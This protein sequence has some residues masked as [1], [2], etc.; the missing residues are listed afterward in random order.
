M[1]QPL[2]KVIVVGNPNKA[3]VPEV[4]EAAVAALK[5]AVEVVSIDLNGDAM[6]DGI[7]ADLAFVFGGDGA[8]LHAARRLGD[9]PMP[10][11]GVKLGKLGFLATLTDENLEADLR[12]VAAGEYT[13]TSAMKLNCAVE[14]N[15]EIVHRSSAVNDAVVSRGAL[16]RLIPIDLLIDGEK[17]TTYNADGIIV[18]TPLGSTAHS[19]AA[20]GPILE[21]GFDAM[22]L[23]P[24][25]PHTLSN[26]PLAI[27]AERQIRLCIVERP[28]GTALTV[29]G[30]IFQDLQ[31]GDC[32]TVARS[33]ARFNLVR[34]TGHSYFRTLRE[35]LG[36]SGHVGT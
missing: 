24:I 8:I 34:A 5:P 17:V 26:R 14:R 6:L 4:I 21:P 23:T 16:S 36:W 32:V 15:G 35:K 13:V 20:G 11:C 22:V 33:E 1:G 12:A 19:L 3:R 30:Q 29:D 7:E 10:V 31:N 27:S 2:N 28:A 18:S 9:N 25:C